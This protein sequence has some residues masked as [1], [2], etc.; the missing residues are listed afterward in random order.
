MKLS[1]SRGNF[2]NSCLENTLH[3]EIQE[4]GAED[5]AGWIEIYYESSL[6]ANSL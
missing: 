3:S 1:N 6:V 5:Y 4:M 2:N